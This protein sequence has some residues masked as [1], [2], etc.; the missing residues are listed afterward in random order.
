M[1]SDGPVTLA[2]LRSRRCIRGEGGRRKR[3]AD[4]RGARPL[5]CLPRAHPSVPASRR[6]GVPPSRFDLEAL[7]I[8]MR[9][10]WVPSAFRRAG[11]LAA[12]TLPMAVAVLL[13]ADGLRLPTAAM[14]LLALMC[15]MVAAALALLVLLVWTVG[16]MWTPGQLL[17]H[18]I[19]GVNR[20]LPA[21]P[22]GNRKAIG[23]ALCGPHHFGRVGAALICGVYAFILMT[24]EPGVKPPDAGTWL[25][26]AELGTMSPCLFAAMSLGTL[27][28]RS[29]TTAVGRAGAILAMLLAFTSLI[30]TIGLAYGQI[31]VTP[32]AVALAA[33]G[34][35]VATSSFL[36][37]AL[38][39]GE[40]AQAWPVGYDRIYVAHVRRLGR[41]VEVRRT[42]RHDARRA[43]VSRAGLDHV[44]A[45]SV[46]GFDWGGPSD[47]A[48]DL[49]RSIL[50]DACGW[51]QPPIQMVHDLTVQVIARLPTGTGWT[52]TVGEV[53]AWS[54]SRHDAHPILPVAV[55]AQLDHYRPTAD[56]R[57]RP[58]RL[59]LPPSGMRRLSAT[60]GRLARRWI[61]RTMRRLGLVERVARAELK[62]NGCDCCG[63]LACRLNRR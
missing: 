30:V 2:V 22:L 32:L 12:V 9:A 41:D 55:A 52:M 44:F 58:V 3:G 14:A 19:A 18:V 17:L 56:R 60:P 20:L 4:G 21:P 37:P 24:A 15:A 42:S 36:G 33:T 35:V 49:A 47:G 10:V 46:S 61:W 54:L 16:V 62:T 11:A 50:V 45:N 26:I 27:S 57:R 29:Q 7:R 8:A 31:S 28:P 53:G 38:F 1:K 39:G 48:L 13:G 59:R 5:G 63:R 34:W 51:A 40:D 6:T 25:Y 23:V 43:D